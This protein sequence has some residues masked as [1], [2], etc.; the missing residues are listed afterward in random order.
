[1]TDHPLG[2]PPHDTA[3]VIAHEI[4]GVNDHIAGVAKALEPYQCDVFTPSFLPSGAVYPREEESRAYSEFMRA[5][6]VTRMSEALTKFTEGL[7]ERYRRVLCIGFS[8]G[9]T[10][11]WLTSGTG[12]VDKAVCI[13]G[14]RIRDHLDVQPAAP[15]LVVF[16]EQEPSY[17]VPAVAER[18]AAHADVATEIYPCSHGFCDPGSPNYS[19]EHSHQAWNSTTRFLGLSQRNRELSG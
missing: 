6:G 9:A 16:A 12:A 17:S 7:R 3:V 4:Y 13:Y 18:L 19:A 15:C 8:V 5:P 14:S 1:M 10:S 2:T 11:A